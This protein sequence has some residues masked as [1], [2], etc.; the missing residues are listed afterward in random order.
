MAQKIVTC[1][2][3][4]KKNRVPDV[5]PDG[6]KLICGG[7]KVDLVDDDDLDDDDTDDEDD[8]DGQ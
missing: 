1:F 8:E 4:S 3:C 2:F 5:V 6:K 7:C